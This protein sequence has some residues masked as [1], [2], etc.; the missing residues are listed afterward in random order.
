[1]D[2]KKHYNILI[3]RAKNRILN[4]Y[5][6]KHHIIPRCMGG[7]D[8]PS[9]L[10][11]LTPEEH[12]VAHQ[13][14]VKIYPNIPEISMAAR[15]MCYG[16]NFNGGRKNNKLFGWLRRKHAEAM[17]EINI[18]KK[19]SPELI[20]KRIAPLR[21]RPRASPSEESI[22]KRTATRALKGSGKHRKPRSEETKRKLSEANLNRDPLLCPHCKLSSRN[23][24]NMNRYHFDN[25]KIIRN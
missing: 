11:R 9:N 24:G 7:I 15:Y 6:E 4:G 20:E 14:L 19:Q 22:K 5:S 10:V 18:G 25:C 13:L 8:D 23:I 12:F 3:E 21:G 2:Y 17:K 16:N 1:M